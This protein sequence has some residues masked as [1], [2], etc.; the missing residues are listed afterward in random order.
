MKN[1]N[2]VLVVED[3]EKWVD[4]YANELNR[5]NCPYA[6][7]R[8]FDEAK[9]CLSGQFFAVAF[10]D[11]RLDERDEANVD[12]LRVL[13][14]I[15]NLDPL[16]SKIVVT[17]HGN[18]VIAREALQTYKAVSIFDKV[19]LTQSGKFLE[20]LQRGLDAYREN[21]SQV[22]W[23]VYDI[24]RGDR[25]GWDWESE[26]IHL[27]QPRGGAHTLRRFFEQLIG[28]FMPV[29]PRDTRSPMVIDRGEGI[30]YGRFWSR[31]RGCGI[32]AVC[33]KVDHLGNIAG[34]GSAEHLS[35]HLHAQVGEILWEREQ[36]NI[37]GFV[38]L[39]GG[40]SRDQYALPTNTVA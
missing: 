6:T 12:G 13:E 19:E 17:G 35:G 33:G 21:E 38:F 25:K 1:L 32:I 23:N 14:L 36:P 27:M 22:H 11:I 10:V 7:A 40:V 3:I 16:T 9:A 18:V 31:A 5:C 20:C 2:S 8:S 39:D 24:C 37:R 34:I 4:I 30:V 28:E 15:Q 26:L 29:I